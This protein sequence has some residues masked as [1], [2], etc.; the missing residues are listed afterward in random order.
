MRNLLVDALSV[1]LRIH[2]GALM[3]TVPDLHADCRVGMLVPRYRVSFTDGK[4]WRTGSVDEIAAQEYCSREGITSR[5]NRLR[6]TEWLQTLQPYVGCR[7][8]QLTPRGDWWKGEL[9]LCAKNF[10]NYSRRTGV[11]HAAQE[12]RLELIGTAA[13]KK[14]LP[15]IRARYRGLTED[16]FLTYRDVCKDRHGFQLVNT[17]TGAE[18]RLFTKAEYTGNLIGEETV[19]QIGHSRKWYAAWGVMMK[20]NCAPRQVEQHAKRSKTAR[21]S[22]CGETGEVMAWLD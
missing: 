20:T 5:I 13:Y 1:L 9:V 3:G 19:Y 6:G 16:S 4:S 15:E 8:L 14:L 21:V 18:S 2:F 7:Y 17:L 10:L 11:P 12:N 22:I